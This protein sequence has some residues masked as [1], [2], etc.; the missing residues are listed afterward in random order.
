LTTEPRW[1]AL[2]A[3]IEFNRHVVEVDGGRHELR[4]L[5][6]LKLAL[7]SPW[8]IRAY[9]RVDDPAVLAATLFA[10]LASVN[11]F[12]HGNQRRLSCAPSPL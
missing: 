4:D 5:A 6:T 7:A 3:A 9:S 11:A 8:S 1:L 12:V 10:D 2:C